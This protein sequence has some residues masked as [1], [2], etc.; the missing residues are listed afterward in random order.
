MA[1]RPPGL[2]LIEV[3]VSFGVLA[4]AIL[5]L[6]GCMPAA[7]RVQKVSTMSSQALYQ[8]EQ[9]LDELLHQNQRLSGVALVDYPYSD[10]SLR[11]RWWGESVDGHPNLQLVQVE[12]TWVEGVRSHLWVL[13]SYLAP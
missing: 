1:R 10:A 2:S 5:G 4:V 13:R 7:A 11:R 9:K 12:V 6:L 3:L 8:A